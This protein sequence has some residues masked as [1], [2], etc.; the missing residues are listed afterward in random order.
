MKF[1]YFL[2]FVI[3]FGC[4][5]SSSEDV[6][7]KEEA[8]F[9]FTVVVD[10]RIRDCFG[11]NFVEN[12]IDEWLIRTNSKSVYYVVYKNQELIEDADLPKPGVIT[13]KLVD[14]G[15]NSRAM[16]LTLAASKTQANIMIQDF[17][18][19]DEGFLTRHILLHELGHAFGL[20]HYVGTERS[21]M[22]KNSDIT[23]QKIQCVDIVSFCSIWN[24]NPSKCVEN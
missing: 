1:V 7:D 12:A 10:S 18:G 16:G 8:V 15:K 6:F 24:C 14:F 11:K 5:A 9:D 3:L 4:S 13:I 2:I 19:L 21:I 22:N 17:R 23:I 20:K